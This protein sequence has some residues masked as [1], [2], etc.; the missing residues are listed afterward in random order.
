MHSPRV[1]RRTSRGT[2]LGGASVPARPLT[3]RD[4]KP[5]GAVISG[6]MTTSVDIGISVHSVAAG[7]RR[8]VWIALTVLLIAAGVAGATF[9]LRSQPGGSG[10]TSAPSMSHYQSSL[11]SSIR[12][13]PGMHVEHSAA[14]GISFA[15][16]EATV[17][18]FPLRHG[19]QR[20]QTPTSLTIREVPPRALHGSFPA[21]GIAVRVL[22]LQTLG[23]IPSSGATH[24]PLR[25]NTF[26][27]AGGNWYSG[28]RP[29]P[30]QQKLA[31]KGRTYYVQVWLGPKASAGQHSRLEQIVA[32]IS[33]RGV[34]RTS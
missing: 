19:V 4:G 34:H 24:P 3:A 18:N 11:G 5:C 6:V 22:W 20:H 12:F 7:M 1:A 9:A 2:T 23:P 32:S 21:H 29:R 28:T 33:S 25:L 15:V 31:L 10:P 13:P 8:R 16:S 26:Q 30:L 17:A 14:G 27:R